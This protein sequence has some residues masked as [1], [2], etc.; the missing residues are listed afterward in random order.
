M[1]RDNGIGP[2]TGEPDMI[3]V[4]NLVCLLIP[5]MLLTATFVQYAA[6]TVTAP[7]LNPAGQP[8][9][10]EPPRLGLTVLV[11]DRGFTLSAHGKV[12]GQSALE[13]DAQETYGPSIPV[14]GSEASADLD[15][16]KLTRML[17]D[18]KDDNEGETS[19]MIGAERNVDFGTIVKVMDASREDQKGELFPQVTWLS[20]V[21]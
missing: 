2:T 4:M 3:P 14:R 17:R 10:S 13:V 7:R 20:G 16:E 9:G 19:I 18:I 15:F 1:K 8:D 6:L 12:L 11:T 5:F 21:M